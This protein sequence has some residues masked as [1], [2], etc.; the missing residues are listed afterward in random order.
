MLRQVIL[1]C[2]VQKRVQDVTNIILFHG[3]LNMHNAILHVWFSFM[4]LRPLVTLALVV[5]IEIEV[6][7]I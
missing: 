1:T 7:F 2:C 6:N 4:V 3:P 5:V